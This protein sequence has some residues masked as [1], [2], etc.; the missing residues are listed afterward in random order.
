MADPSVRVKPVFKPRL[1]AAPALK[2]SA[3]PLVSTTK[4]PP[5]LVRTSDTADPLLQPNIMTS[6]LPTRRQVEIFDESELYNPPAKV[7]KTTVLRIK[8]KRDEQSL[9]AIGA[10][11]TTFFLPLMVIESD[12]NIHES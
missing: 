9:D 7:K 3:A 1:P 8:R 10:F 5:K 11:S 2:K 4:G 6:H 12:C